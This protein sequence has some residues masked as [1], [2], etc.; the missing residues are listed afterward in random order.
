[1]RFPFFA[2][3]MSVLVAGCAGNPPLG[4]PRYPSAVRV[5]E[6]LPPPSGRDVIL[7]AQSYIIGPL[8]KLNVSVF[9]IG[10]L[11]GDVQADA[12]GQI[13]LPLIGT[14]E[15][16]GNTPVQ[17]SRIITSAYDRYVRNPVVS[18]NIREATSQTFTVDGQVT[19]PGIYPVV[20]NMS[21][22]RAI[23]NA[24]GAAEFAKLDDVVVFRTVNGERMAALYNLGAIRRGMYADP[25]IYSNDI[26]VVGESSSRRLFKDFLQV[27]P[28]LAAPVVLLLQN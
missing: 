10:E 9:G 27:A 5:A 28:A 20:G 19:E 15:A 7:S 21:L 23:A 8:D 12:S 16:A 13:T 24:K 22:M 18:V 4:D 14:I 26:I 6:T 17:L 11:S 1:M 25:Q 3:T 2:A